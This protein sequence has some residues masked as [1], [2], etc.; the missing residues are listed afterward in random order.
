MPRV[1]PYSVVFPQ[2]IPDLMAVANSTPHL[3][4]SM[5]SLAAVIA[6]TSLRRP[7]VRALLHHQETLRKVQDL[8]SAGGIEETTVYA[9][10]MLAYFNV[11]S[12]RFLSARRHLRGFSILLDQY[13]KGTQFPSTTMMLIWRCAVRLDYFVSSVYPCKPIFP[14]P[15]VEQE[16]LHR[17]WIHAAVE[18]SNE[19]WAM[20]QFALDNLQSRAAHLSWTAYQARRFGG[21]DENAILEQCAQLLNDFTVWRA[22]KVMVEEEALEELVERL[23][24]SKSTG[25]FV[26]HPPMNTRN[27]FYANL[28]NEFRA[29]VLFITFIASPVIA[30][31]SPYDDVRRRQAIDLCRSIAATGISLFPMPIVRT[32]QL[33]G[34]VFYDPVENPEECM[35]IEDQLQQ[36]ADRGILAASRVKEMLL[37]VWNSTFLWT[38]DDTE[39]LMQ[40]ED[41]LDQLDQEA[42]V[43]EEDASPG[44]SSLKSTEVYDDI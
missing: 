17:I 9:V 13:S 30:N 34:L 5:I 22:R 4:H 21:S 20:A 11:F 44:G 18:P 41:D 39:R 23:R 16:E 8:L 29:S 35:W 31:P 6:D 40:N 12:G 24:P 10:M 38:Y 42:E 43:Y 2:F 27:R 25:T 19:E 1:H 7:L 36:V 28:W 26:G 15:P 14:A 37:V 3:R 33:A 32:L